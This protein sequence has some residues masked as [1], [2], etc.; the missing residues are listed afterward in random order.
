MSPQ[1]KQ[2]PGPARVGKLFV[3]EGVD[4]SGKTTLSR[5]FAEQVK[6]IGFECEWFAFPGRDTGTLGK[7]VYELHHHQLGM[8]IKTINPTSLQ[9]LHVAAHI[10][11]IEARIL[12]ALRQG[13]H[14]VLDRFW[15]STFVYGTVAGADL[16]SLKAMI[17]VE[18]FHWGRVR[19][20]LAFLVRRKVP[21]DDGLPADTNLLARAYAKLA[22]REAQSYPV[23][24]IDNDGTVPETL[25]LLTNI[26]G[27]K[28]PS[29]TALPRSEHSRQ[30]ANPRLR[31][32]HGGTG[33][34]TIF[35]KLLP[36][37]PTVVYDTYWRFV[38]ERQAIFFRRLR[39]EL[40]PWTNDPILQE[41][42]FTNAYRA[43]DRTSQY[44]IRKVI[45]AGDQDPDEIVFRT[46]LFKLFNRIETW[47]L[48]S[49]SVGHISYRDYSFA[50]YDA[51][52]TEAMD[53][54]QTIYSAAYIMPSGGRSSPSSRKHRLHL[55]LIEQMLTDDLPTRLV[56]AKSMAKAFA[57]LRGYAT[58]GDF[59]A[60]QYVTDLNYGTLLNFTEMDFVVPGP[61]SRDGIRKCFSDLGGLNETEII[62]LVT[63]RQQVEFG[64]LGLEFQSLWGRPLQL[65]DCQNVFCEVDKYARVKHP[66]FSGHTGRTRIKQ[67]YRITSSPISY[68]YPPK[69]GLN[70]RIAKGGL[71]VSDF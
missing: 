61:G 24:M 21:T 44:L 50:E 10:D 43:S 8:G 40:P 51:V 17:D 15:W 28:V 60:Y 36:A 39:S 47:E 52:L 71:L 38:A 64:R 55:R 37:K 26:A 62:K 5:A 13:R 2:N 18:R 45:Y 19:P 70:E 4:G 46:L 29:R 22:T 59:L 20:T 16:R 32:D 65:I 9:L 58:I 69:W 34:P 63:E 49:R 33:F 42:K 53:R 27:L 30:R 31:P 6:A 14:V 35:S 66:E 54:G 48:L 11:A 7:H 67:R 57:L 12:P 41:Y 25:V 3:F 56:H 23:I 1:T 68:W